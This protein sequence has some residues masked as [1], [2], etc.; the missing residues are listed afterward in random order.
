V[1]ETCSY[2]YNKTPVKIVLIVLTLYTDI[3]YIYDPTYRAEVVELLNPHDQELTDDDVVE[4]RNQSALEGADE[5]GPGPGPGPG[6]EPKERTV[7]VLKSAEGLVLTET[8]SNNWSRVY[9]SA[10]LL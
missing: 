3:I 1:A 10:W 9:E 8:G 4:I 2:K 5:P 6:P 7:T